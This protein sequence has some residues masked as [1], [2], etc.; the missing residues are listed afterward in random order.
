MVK[1][2]RHNLRAMNSYKESNIYIVDYGVLKA[3]ISEMELIAVSEANSSGRIP[4]DTHKRKFEALWRNLLQES[5]QSV[6]QVLKQL[7]LKIFSDIQSNAASRGAD[8]VTAIKMFVRQEGKT[9][10]GLDRCASVLRELRLLLGA[11]INNQE[12][13]RKA[14]KKYDKQRATSE[15]PLSPILLSELFG[16]GGL[17]GKIEKWVA[18][19]T[20]EIKKLD[21]ETS[22]LLSRERASSVADSLL[23]ADESEAAIFSTSPSD[24]EIEFS[25]RLK[26]KEEI[27]WLR[28]CVECL[29]KREKLVLHRGFHNVSDE[30]ARP[31]ENSLTSFE[32]AWS[33]GIHACE[34]DVALT[35]DGYVILCHDETFQRLALFDENDSSKKKVSD[36]TLREIMQLPLKSGQRPPL[37][38]DCLESAVRISENAS[39]VIEIKPGN[40]AMG[41][42]L[43]EMFRKKMHLL[44]AV[45]VVMSFDLYAIHE[46]NQE[47]NNLKSELAA[48]EYCGPQVK[49]PKVMLLTCSAP[50]ELPVYLAMSI[51]D[52]S[53]KGL[54]GDLKVLQSW[55]ERSGSKLDGVYIQVS[56]CRA[57]M[58]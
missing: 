47:L 51:T 19:I 40:T 16:E 5:R 58:L 53:I 4:Q 31:I 57:V 56:D 8:V 30:G 11:E 39:L 36:L 17:A 38:E 29:E 21:Y 42:A 46:F 18:V 52:Q 48:G 32:T 50:D 26:F 10:A 24:N 20:K 45:S 37:L 23:S 12:A 14:I 15:P 6:T 34:C 3:C 7:L 44:E 35:V 1:F 2:G 55:L 49:F 27:E 22:D 33:A 9:H 13:L 25:R 54:G 28:G 43:C 41:K